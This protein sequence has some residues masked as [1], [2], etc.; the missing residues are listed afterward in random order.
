MKQ[1]ITI[2]AAII[3]TAS[4]FAQAPNKMS[5][6][7]VIRNSSN[8]LVSN[9]SVGMRISILQDSINGSAVYTET[10]VPTTNINGLASLEIGGGV[11]VSGT[12]SSIDWANGPYFVKTE[13]DPA[14]GT[15]Y[16]ITGT[17]QLL[18]VPY[19]LYA[20][21]TDSWKVNADTSYTDNQIN[22]GNSTSSGLMTYPSYTF[23][24][25][26]TSANKSRIGL[27]RVDNSINGPAVLFHKARGTGF[28]S[29]NNVN[30]GDFL[31]AIG[32]TGFNGVNF[33]DPSSALITAIAKENFTQSS[34]GT[35]LQFR[36]AAIGTAGTT[37][38]VR[39]EIRSE[40]SVIYTPLQNAPSNPVRGET[41]FDSTLNKLRVFDGTTWQNCW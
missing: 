9:Q 40:G 7:A 36:T 33:T 16:S 12:F 27:S 30:S 8:A 15:S 39:F 21:N 37:P 34:Q 4:V 24:V 41:Y 19:S 38:L 23:N 35:N 14:G 25:M 32:F 11:V 13:T 28:G 17:S 18:S 1:I 6:Q 29:K 3:T 22:V 2:C 10:Q 31:G 20:K 26:G 5:Y